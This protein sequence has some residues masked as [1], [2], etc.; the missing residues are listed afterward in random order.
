M[1][2]TTTQLLIVPSTT[3]NL[4]FVWN[5]VAATYQK[6]LIR[7]AK[8]LSVPGFRKGTV[9][10][11][12]AEE[13]IAAQ[14]IVE[15]TLQQLLPE[16]YS[17][18]ITKQHFHPLTSPDF[19]L[20]SSGKNQDWII[21]VSIAEKPPLMLKD[22]QKVVSEAKQA[23]AAA[24]A[25]EKTKP[26]EHEER[27]I[28]LQ[29]IYG[30]LAEKF[31]PQVPELL[32][33]R[34]IEQDVENMN[35]QLKRLNLTLADYLKRNE[36]TEQTFSQQVTVRALTRLQSI[37]LTDAIAQLE[38]I[39]ID[40]KAIDTTIDALPETDFGKKER[41]NPDYRANLHQTL[42]TQAVHNQLLKN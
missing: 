6:T 37:L 16:R 11:A 39:T 31:R 30:K 1:A 32:L 33:K 41:N 4:T 13:Q 7:L 28:Q 14:M 10:A 36:L 5:D 19:R 26:K 27:S 40:E 35:T 18:E 21:K 29:F 8:R 20:V 22:Y 34:E 12:V 2:K 9:P 15:Q 42:F 24:I 25:K 38:E 3:F 17:Q 23:A